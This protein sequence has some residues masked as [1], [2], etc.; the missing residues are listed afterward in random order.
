MI[1]RTTLAGHLCWNCIP[2]CN[3]R[4]RRRT[5]GIAAEGTAPLHYSKCLPSGA[6]KASS[7]RSFGQIF[8]TDSRTHLRRPNKDSRRKRPA[9]IAPHGASRG[10]ALARQATRTPRHNG[11]GRSNDSRNYCFWNW[12]YILCDECVINNTFIHIYIYTYTEAIVECWRGSP[13][14]CRKL[15]KFAAVSTEKKYFSKN[16]Q[17]SE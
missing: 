15:A 4:G 10:P 12:Q 3:T 13:S 7:S 6:S 16:Y 17:S 2:A 8:R 9:R 14:N 5:W 1:K 11:K